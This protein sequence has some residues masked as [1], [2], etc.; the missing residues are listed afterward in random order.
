MLCATVLV[1]AP[2]WGRLIVLSGQEMTAANNVAFLSLYIF[3]AIGF[4]WFNRGRVHP[5]YGW[6]IGAL[7]AMVIAVEALAAFPPFV[8]MAERIAG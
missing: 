4:D 7:L 6:G 8:T 2:A 3:V 1:I 5:A